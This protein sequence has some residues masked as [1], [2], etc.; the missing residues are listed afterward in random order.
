MKVDAYPWLMVGW[1]QNHGK[2]LLIS[3]KVSKQCFSQKDKLSQ[4]TSR[5][6]TKSLQFCCM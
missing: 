4:K 6:V 2:F 3:G 1:C 5:V